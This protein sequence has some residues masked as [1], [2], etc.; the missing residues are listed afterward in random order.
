MKLRNSIAS[1]APDSM[2]GSLEILDTPDVMLSEH[3]VSI[4]G[5]SVGDRYSYALAEHAVIYKFMRR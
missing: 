5:Q 1:A 4:L 2:D 3:V